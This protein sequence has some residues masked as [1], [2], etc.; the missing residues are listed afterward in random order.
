MILTY[1]YRIKDK[2][3]INILSRMSFSVNQVWNFC[4]ATQKKTQLLY[5]QG[6]NTHWLSF[7]D[8]GSLTKGTSKELG[9]HAQTSKCICKQFVQ[10]RNQ[11]KKCPKFRVSF[12]SKKSL[13]WIPFQEQSRQ[14][15]TDSISYLGNIFKLFGIKRRPIPNKVTGGSFVEDSQG[16]W[17]VC[18]Y[19]DVPN[20]PTGT[21]EVGIDLGLKTLA[22]LSTG[23]K[24]ENPKT[25]YKYE[26]KLAV[27]QR[28][29]NKK[30]VKAIHAKIKNIR[31]DFLHK[32][33]HKI[34]AENKTIIV[35]NVNSTKLA[36]THLAKSVMNSSWYKFRTMLEYKASRHQAYFK[37]VNEKFTT[38]T[39]STC[40]TLPESRPKGI[41]G[42]GI[43]EWVCSNCNTI[44]DRDTN[45]SLNILKL[46]QSVLPLAEEILNNK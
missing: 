32:A 35:G 6:S 42:L 23:E 9:I 24:I 22:T 45:S 19:V 41:A 7:F 21:G 14:V 18:L 5:K 2:N 12:G 27:A 25:Y 38:Q 28:A 30:R 17:Y 37:I 39:C 36:K 4:V 10:S 8:L 34:A 20:L 3:K 44:H 16:K 11:H 13:G 33:S 31:K 29:H 46:G 43:R 40:G 15:G 26:E 1:K